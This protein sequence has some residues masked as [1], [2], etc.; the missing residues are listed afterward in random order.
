MAVKRGSGRLLHLH[1]VSF[2]SV[3]QASEPCVSDYVPARKHNNALRPASRSRALGLGLTLCPASRPQTARR[4]PET[5]K[6]SLFLLYDGSLVVS[7][8]CN[9]I[10]DRLGARRDAL[11]ENVGSAFRKTRSLGSATHCLTILLLN[12][13][14]RQKT[15]S[16]LLIQVRLFI[17]L[18]EQIKALLWNSRDRKRCCRDSRSA[19]LPVGSPEKGPPQESKHHNCVE[20]SPLVDMLRLSGPAGLHSAH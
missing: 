1:R 8:E 17:S 5:A 20:R 19:H 6:Q 13:G 4:K 11:W 9:L 10:R 16:V 18:A 2:C 3:K 15:A 14:S 7:L 12:A